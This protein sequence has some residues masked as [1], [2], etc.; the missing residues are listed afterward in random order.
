MI[1][2]A[3]AEKRRG[4]VVYEAKYVIESG[5]VLVL[6]KELGRRFLLQGGILR[7]WCFLLWHSLSGNTTIRTTIA[8]AQEQECVTTS[9]GLCFRNSVTVSM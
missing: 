9:V 6:S 2:N 4:I 3:D 8:P 5:E 1:F 7:G